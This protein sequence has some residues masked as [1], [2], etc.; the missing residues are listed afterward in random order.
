MVKIHRRDRSFEGTEEKMSDHPCCR[1]NRG[2]INRVALYIGTSEIDW[3]GY[4]FGGPTLR[5]T[6]GPRV[7]LKVGCR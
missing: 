6:I 3:M 4:I 1:N 2:R 5:P 7:V